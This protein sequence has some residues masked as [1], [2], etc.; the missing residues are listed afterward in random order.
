MLA[1]TC[2]LYVAFVNLALIKTYLLTYLLTY[3]RCIFQCISTG[4]RR[5]NGLAQ[6]PLPATPQ[7]MDSAT[8]SAHFVKFTNLTPLEK[9]GLA[10]WICIMQM[11][12]KWADRHTSLTHSTK[13]SHQR[14]MYSPNYGLT[15][16]YGPWRACTGSRGWRRSSRGSRGSWWS[17]RW[18]WGSRPRRSGGWRQTARW[19]D[20]SGSARP[21]SPRCRP[22][23]ERSRPAV[24][25]THHRQQNL[26]AVFVVCTSCMFTLV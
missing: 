19:S 23:A 14:R 10:L 15:G 13:I 5:K 26:L 4:A 18:W 25:N 3:L 1:Q 24:I 12:C 6:L 8:L 22:P 17:I 7:L 9:N 21:P 16:L 11:I 2:L 20:R